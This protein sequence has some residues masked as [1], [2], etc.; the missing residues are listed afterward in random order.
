MLIFVFVRVFFTNKMY[1]ILTHF[2]SATLK[3]R[4]VM[5]VYQSL[6][7]VI[8]LRR[9]CRWSGIYD[10]LLIRK[11]PMNSVGELKLRLSIDRN[12][13]GIKKTNDSMKE[14]IKNKEN[15]K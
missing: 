2:T 4:L 1:L 13:F 8:L 3:S 11:D 12:S 14:I 10:S 15:K 7:Y 6:S 5:Y 9:P